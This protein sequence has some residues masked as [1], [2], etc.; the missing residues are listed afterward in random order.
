[1]RVSLSPGQASRRVVDRLVEAELPREPLCRKPLQVRARLLGRHHQGQGRRVR[2]DDQVVGEAAFQAE[3]RHSE[4][5]VLIG[6]PRVEQVVARLGNPPRDA[7]TLRVLDLAPDR[8]LAGLVEQGVV[9]A[10]HDDERHQVLE[11][12][13]APRQQDRLP[14]RGRQQAPER[15]P[16]LLRQ[17][18]L[19]DRHEGAEA[20]LRGEKVVVA[21]VA[22]AI[23]DVV[24]DRQEVAGPVEQKGP[25]H[26]RQIGRLRGEAIQQGDPGPGRAGPLVVERRQLAERRDRREPGQVRLRPRRR[27]QRRPRGQ[28]REIVDHVAALGRQRRGPGARFTVGR[29]RQRSGQRATLRGQAF[30]HQPAI[31]NGRWRRVARRAERLL[32]PRHG[33][34]RRALDA[35]GHE[36][37]GVPKA[38]ECPCGQDR[39]A[40]DLEQP[41][42]QRHQVA[43]QVAAVHRRDEA[44]L[45]R[46][47][48][49]A[50]CTSC[51]NGPDGAPSRTSP[52]TPARCDPGAGPPRCSR[53]RRP[54]DWPAAPAPCWLATCDAPRRRRAPPGSCPAA[55]SDR[56]DRHRCRRSP[57]SC[58]RR[59][60]GTGAGG[61]SAARHAA[62]ADG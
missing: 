50:C 21:R 45:E 59:H 10:R 20:R 61:P 1:M 42:A 62:T 17:V 29:R 25:L 28:V 48:A 54:R 56:L 35:V 13:A 7:A 38:L 23:G 11:H 32:Q 8:R 12:R 2:R 37:E 22:T 9:V 14:R 19:R 51:R 60:S 16:A 58:G 49:T 46:A 3:A 43:R 4:R 26:V 24:A 52:G 34:R 55:A 18:P 6:E 5:A 15:E 57:R 30:E 39:L 44:R 27:R 36:V 40:C 41:L 31:G 47:R 33:G 53:S